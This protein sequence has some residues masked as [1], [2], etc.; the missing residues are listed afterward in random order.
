MSQIQNAIEQAKAAAGQLA[1]QLP[2]IEMEQGVGN[3]G[4]VTNYAPVQAASL[5]GFLD[6]GVALKVDHWLQTTNMGFKIKG[7]NLPVDG[8]LTVLISARNDMQPFYGLRLNIGGKA[9]YF[10]TVDRVTCLKSGKPWGQVLAEGANAGQR[11]YKGFDIRFSATEDIKD[12]KGAVVALAGTTL[13]Y[14]TAITNFNDAADFARK[15]RERGLVD[16]TVQVSIANDVRTNDANKE[17]WGA[18]VFNDFAE[19]TAA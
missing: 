19:A 7:T 15:L 5:D 6:A 3:A 10:K 17:G 9:T 11:E 2:V 14:S 13:G 1:G 4:A 18:V 12:V 8:D 16:A